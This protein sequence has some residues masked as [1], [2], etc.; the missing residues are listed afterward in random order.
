MLYYSIAHYY[1]VSS[2][3]RRNKYRNIE[4][5]INAFLNLDILDKHFILISAIDNL[6]GDYNS[7]FIL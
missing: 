2:H 1:D 3:R 5:H 7:L 4:N 6:R